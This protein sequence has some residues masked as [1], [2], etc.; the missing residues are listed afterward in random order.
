MSALEQ[1]PQTNNKSTF[2]QTQEEKEKIEINNTASFQEAIEAGNLTEAASWLEKVKSDPKYD[3]RWLD[4][5]SREI[6]RA[7]CDAG[8]IDEAEKYI[9]YAQNEKGRRGREE[10]INRLHKQNK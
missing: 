4:H 1:F 2:E 6:M 10:K 9:D 5:R 8:Q 3:A 7:F